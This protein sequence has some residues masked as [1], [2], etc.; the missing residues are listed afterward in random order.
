MNTI[1]ILQ[2]NCWIFEKKEN[3]LKL[4]QDVT[5]DI[6]CL[7]ELTIGS[8]FQNKANVIEFLSQELGMEQ[9]HHVI[10]N[11]AAS[12]GVGD[13]A[14]GIL[15]R[16]PIAQTNWAWIQEPQKGGNTYDD[17]YR[18]Y[19]EAQLDIAG[20][21]LTVGTTHTSYTHKFEGNEQSKIESD[22]LLSILD[23]EKEKFIFTGD[24]NSEPDSYL[25]TE[26]QKHLFN[27]GPDKSEK[28]WTTKPFDYNGFTASTLDWRLDYM[29][30]TSDIKVLDS[31][32]VPTDFSDH[33]PLLVTIEYPS[34]P[35][36]QSFV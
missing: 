29:F 31:K 16:F 2:W 20:S 17:Q 33:L 8:T 15:S 9:F 30:G 13:L 18:L 6:A 7:Q 26:I 4:I 10:P 14:N 5:P 11:L 28:T 1:K 25:I 36:E 21:P 22:Q 23:K 35:N 24:L 34:T 19:V 12:A 32:V 3:V 27:L